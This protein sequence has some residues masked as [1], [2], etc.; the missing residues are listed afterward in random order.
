MRGCPALSRLVRVAWCPS[1]V[2]VCTL[3]V[4]RIVHAQ[5]ADEL[6]KLLVLPPA[7][8]KPLSRGGNDGLTHWAASG[9]SGSDLSD[10]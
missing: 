4:A 3:R 2:A 6:R 10:S 5:V 7:L 9:S 8:R 1:H